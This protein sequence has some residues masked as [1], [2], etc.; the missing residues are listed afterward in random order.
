MF[1]IGALGDVLLTTPL[2]RAVRQRFPVAQIDYLT[3]HWSAPALKNNPHLNQILTFPDEIVQKRSF[4]QLLRLAADVRRRKY[5]IIFILDPGWQVKVLAVFFGLSRQTIRFKPGL[6]DSE[7]YLAMGKYLG[8][9]TENTRLELIRSPDDEKYAAAALKD[10]P[11]PRIAICPGGAK[12][13]YQDMPARRWPPQSYAKL[14][15]QLKVRGF[16]VIVLANQNMTL[17]QTAAVMAACDVVITHDQG[18]MHV[19]AT[20]GTPIL[21]LFG[22]TDPQLKRPL[23]EQHRIIWKANFPCHQDGKLKNCGPA[24]D[25]QAISVAEVLSAALR[26]LSA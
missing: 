23:G 21:A 17:A 11:S 9:Q 7:Q 13:P 19:A 14:I 10:L 20:A 16:G 4:I 3:G 22:P 24:H 8:C 2:V 25:M 1:K 15:R 5:D 26:L 6:H 18:L 12:N